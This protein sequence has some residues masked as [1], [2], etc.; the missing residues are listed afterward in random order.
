MKIVMAPRECT[1]CRTIFCADC[2]E[3]WAKNNTKCPLKCEKAVYV[4]MHRI[5]KGQLMKKRFKCPI[6]GCVYK[7]E[8]EEGYEYMDAIDH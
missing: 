4:D 2:I 1:G 5:L 6:E 3:G 8:G 7:G